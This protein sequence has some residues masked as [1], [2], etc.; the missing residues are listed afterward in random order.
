MISVIV[1][2][3]YYVCSSVFVC[4]FLISSFSISYLGYFGIIFLQWEEVEKRRRSLFMLMVITD[5]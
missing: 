5:S 1:G 3:S 2:Y 4:I